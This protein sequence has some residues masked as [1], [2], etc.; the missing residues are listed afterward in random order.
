[1]RRPFVALAA[2]GALVLTACAAAQAPPRL[3]NPCALPLSRH[4]IGTGFSTALH[5][6]LQWVDRGVEPPHA[7]RNAHRRP[8]PAQ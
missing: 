1:M 2:A 4:P 7:P 5:H 6:L 3:P 8:R